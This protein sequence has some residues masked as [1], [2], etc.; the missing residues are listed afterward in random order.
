MRLGAL[1]CPHEGLGVPGGLAQ[2]LGGLQGG[3]LGLGDAAALLIAV[4]GVAQ[5]GIVGEVLGPDGE[6]FEA[7]RSELA[8]SAS[9]PSTV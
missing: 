2:V 4:F 6:L 5:G 1:E 7:W 9:P 3:L 8:A